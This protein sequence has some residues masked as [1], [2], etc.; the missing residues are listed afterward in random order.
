MKNTLVEN[1]ILVK[2]GRAAPKPAPQHGQSAP[3][4]FVRIE[5]IFKDLMVSQ[6]KIRRAWTTDDY[7]VLRVHRH[8]LSKRMINRLRLHGREGVKREDADGLHGISNQ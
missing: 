5:N 2:I 1:L 8:V 6:T 7:C 3:L 4:T